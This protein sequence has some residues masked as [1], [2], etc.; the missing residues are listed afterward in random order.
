MGERTAN[1]GRTGVASVVAMAMILLYA[2]TT[3]AQPTPL[4]ELINLSFDNVQPTI[5]PEDAKS[6]P[7]QGNAGTCTLLF[8][9]TGPS[10]SWRAYYSDPDRLQ[11]PVV[12]DDASY[13]KVRATPELQHCFTAPPIVVTPPNEHI[14]YV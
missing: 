7:Y 13:Q 6:F 9:Q 2:S 4:E 1:A 5:N 3:V 12:V 8:V 11:P 14:Q 10:G